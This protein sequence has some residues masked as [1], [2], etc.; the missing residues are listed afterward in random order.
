MKKPDA[1][2]AAIRQALKKSDWHPLI[3][4][5]RDLER[6][7]PG[8]PTRTTFLLEIAKYVQAKPAAVDADGNTAPVLEVR[9]AGYAMVP[10]PNIKEGA[11]LRRIQNGRG[12]GD[13]DED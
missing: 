5:A 10:P 9:I 7:K 8:D 12:G 4:M 2:L 1:L 13:A 6:M 11:P 3:E